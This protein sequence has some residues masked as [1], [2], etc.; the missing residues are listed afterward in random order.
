M[1]ARLIFL[2][3]G[4]PQSR[5]SFALRPR[6]SFSRPTSFFFVAFAR[7]GFLPQ[8]FEFAFKIFYQ[9]HES[10]QHAAPGV[11][12]QAKRKS[13][14][15]C[16]AGEFSPPPAH[17]RPPAP[18]SVCFLFVGSLGTPGVH[19]FFLSFLPHSHS[20]ARIALL[21]FCFL[22]VRRPRRVLSSFFL[23]LCQCPGCS[24]LRGMSICVSPC[25][26]LGCM[27]SRIRS[28]RSTIS[29]VSFCPTNSL[30]C[31]ALRPENMTATEPSEGA[32]DTRKLKQKN[33]SRKEEQKQTSSSPF[34]PFVFSLFVTRLPRNSQEK[35]SL[36]SV[37]IGRSVY[38]CQ[39][40]FVFFLLLSLAF[41]P[42][43][44]P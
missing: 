26:F 40:L 13:R 35:L 38:L 44:F 41:S 20:H 5:R 14:G 37:Q 31:S 6:R 17:R 11:T 21:L 33:D 28:T 24:R 3:F 23:L 34:L 42:S 15:R 2:A 18:P 36:A 25:L 30:P 1:G 19:L 4:V 10:L 27:Y 29:A 16:F 8:S 43:F 22:V 32:S 7:R 9:T 12:Q 39:S